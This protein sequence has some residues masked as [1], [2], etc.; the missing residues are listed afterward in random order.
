M[1]CVPLFKNVE[2]CIF[3]LFFRTNSRRKPAH[4][5]DV[6]VAERPVRTRRRCPNSKYI[7]CINKKYAKVSGAPPPPPPQ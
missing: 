2:F 7:Q 4:V 5:S 1:C 3:D 6:S